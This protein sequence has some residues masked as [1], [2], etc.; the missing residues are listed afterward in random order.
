MQRV[1]REDLKGQTFIK[2]I[3]PVVLFVKYLA[4]LVVILI[5]TFLSLYEFRSWF[6]V[7]QSV[8]LPIFFSFEK[9]PDLDKLPLGQPLRQAAFLQANFSLVD[10]HNIELL[11]IPQT[12]QI[13]IS[14]IGDY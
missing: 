9:L 10:R 2:I 8:T 7:S 3:L 13:E 14:L 6:L 5:L 4:W 12:Y 1:E 11:T